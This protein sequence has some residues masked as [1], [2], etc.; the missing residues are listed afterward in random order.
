MDDVI[1]L[2]YNA[3]TPCDPRVVEAMMPFFNVAPANP[4]SRSHRPGRRAFE[5][6]ED[7][8]ATVA[9]CLN[10]RSATEIVFTSGATEANNL[11]LKGIRPPDGHRPPHFVTQATEHSSILEPARRLE[12]TG[13]KV[14]VLGVD[15]TGR[16]RLDRLARSLA[17][18]VTMVSIMAANNETGTTQEINRVARLAHEHGA[19]MH[20]DAAQAFGKIA[21]DVRKLEVDLLSLSGHKLYGPKGVGALYVR[22]RRPP[23]RLTPSLDGG[24]QEHGMRSGTVNLPAVVGLARAL[25][26]AADDLVAGGSRLAA[27]RDRLEDRVTTDL[28]GVHVNGNREHRLPGTT[29]LA[30]EGVDGNAL[31]AALND[32]ALSSGSACASDHGA[33]SHVITAMGV[34]RRLA[35]ASLRISL[36]RPTTETEV[37]RATERIVAEVHRLRALR[38]RR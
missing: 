22:R 21:V 15:T 29:N 9:R 20:C 34:P 36:G 17:G 10:A 24:G 26:I 8:R 18:G 12:A 37:D 23:I 31:L 35:S 38:R 2:D 16:V 27:L 28:D 19:L 6:L 14:T 7:A 33:P 30:F 4:M 32:L 25:E 11:A 3:S 5:T 13:W 1:Y